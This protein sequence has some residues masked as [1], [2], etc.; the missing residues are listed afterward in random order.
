M[1][2]ISRFTKSY[3]FY[4]LKNRL[5]SCP[6]GSRILNITSQIK[7]IINTSYI[8]YSICFCIAS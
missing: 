4:L 7:T 2:I 5:K 6:T 3:R 1:N 8:N